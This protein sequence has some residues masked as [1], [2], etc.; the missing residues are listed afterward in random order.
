MAKDSYWFRH[1]S[2]SGRGMRIR[3]IQHLYGHEGKG[4]YWDVIEVLREQENYSYPSDESSLQM[5]SDLIG[6]KDPIRFENWFKDCIKIGLFV[7]KNEKFHSE[8]LSH[9]MIKW[10]T[11]KQAG[12]QSG[13]SRNERKLNETTNEI[14]TKHEHKIREEDR[15]EEKK[16]GGN[17]KKSPPP[18]PLFL[19][20]NLFKEKGLS[21]SAK[22]ESQKFWDYNASINWTTKS[23]EKTTDDLSKFVDKWISKMEEDEITPPYVRQKEDPNIRPSEL[24]TWNSDMEK[25]EITHES[26]FP[27]LYKKK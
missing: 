7:I 4:I 19:I 12:I 14:L 22:V 11:T 21:K 17:G 23:G 5:L 26:F 9:N 15:R 8:V 6:F 18:P 2:T 3:K 25:W 13:K 24:H 20:E 10:E 16:G 1:D 27:D